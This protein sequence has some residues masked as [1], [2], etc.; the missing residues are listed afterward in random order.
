MNESRSLPPPIPLPHTHVCLPLRLF[1]HKLIILILIRDILAPSLEIPLFLSIFTVPPRLLP[2]TPVA[3][4]SSG[5]RT[6]PRCSAS[7]RMTRGKETNTR[8]RSSALKCAWKVSSSLA[9]AEPFFLAGDRLAMTN[10]FFK[11]PGTY[12]DVYTYENPF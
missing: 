11:L 2:L 7:T 12:G 1:P 4:V 9:G 3:L 8:S 5:S 10:L 6:S